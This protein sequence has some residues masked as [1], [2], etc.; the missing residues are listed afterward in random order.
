MKMDVID[1]SQQSQKRTNF[2]ENCGNESVGNDVTPS[3]D[4]IVRFTTKSPSP[5]VVV[6]MD[7]GI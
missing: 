7:D 4:R 1:G 2:T 3:A 5:K 6:E